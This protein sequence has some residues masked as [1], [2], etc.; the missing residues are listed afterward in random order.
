M[1]LNLDICN[2]STQEAEQKDY[3]FKDSMGYMERSCLKKNNLECACVTDT[4]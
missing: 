3:E 4:H 2:L 1:F